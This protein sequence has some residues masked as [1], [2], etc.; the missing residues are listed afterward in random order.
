M[1]PGR[2]AAA[3][4]LCSGLTLASLAAARGVPAGTAQSA[5]TPAPGDSLVFVGCPL[6]RDT[7]TVPCWLAEHEGELYYLGSQGSTSSAFYPPQLLHESLVEATVGDGP[8]VCGGRPLVNV[9]V[10]VLREL[11][12]ACNTILPA[13]PQ[14]TAPPSPP[15]TIPAFADDTREFRVPYDFDSDYLTLHTTR[16]LH[17]VVRIARLLD[18]GRVEVEGVRTSVRLSDGR[19][20]IER[21]ELA[22]ERAEDVAKILR[23]LGVDAS[24]IHASWRDDI[25]SPDGRT[26]RERRVTV[27]RLLAP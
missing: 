19:T 8:R 14:Y 21:E 7:S 5:T 1:T 18:P 23:G 11:N 25:D 20:L 13:E 22:R 3:V 15:A 6:I 26:D 27:I 16:I 9:E 4:V 2:W 10:S 17:E 12:R 24:R